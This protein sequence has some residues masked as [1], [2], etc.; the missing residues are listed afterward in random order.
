[1]G[2]CQQNKLGHAS[3]SL[4]LLGKSLVLNENPFLRYKKMPRQNPKL[5]VQQNPCYFSTLATDPI[6]VNGC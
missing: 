6:N 4:D 3:L 5:H 1:V 2:I